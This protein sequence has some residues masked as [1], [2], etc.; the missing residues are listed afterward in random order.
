MGLGVIYI[1]M[2]KCVGVG[3]TIQ[4]YVPSSAGF[5]R[6]GGMGVIY[7]FMGKC[8]GA[9]FTIQFLVPQLRRAMR[10]PTPITNTFSVSQF[11]FFHSKKKNSFCILTRGR[12]SSFSVN[13]AENRLLAAMV[14]VRNIQ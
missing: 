6:G 14:L 4:F 9:G 13:L 5:A 1:F 7:I 8:V 2:G 11:L 10:P 3:L 12:R